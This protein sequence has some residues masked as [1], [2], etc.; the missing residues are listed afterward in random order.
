MNKI[1]QESIDQFDSHCEYESIQIQICE[2]INNLITL[3]MEVPDNSWLKDD[4]QDWL[5][6]R[7]IS[8]D[9][10]NT[11]AELLEKV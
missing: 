11:K 10:G 7:H 4:I 5:K 6:V 8:Y 2:K 9:N 3:L 1:T